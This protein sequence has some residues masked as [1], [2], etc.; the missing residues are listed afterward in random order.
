VAWEDYRGPFADIFL[1]IVSEDGEVELGSDGSPLC[2]SPGDQK[3]PSLCISTWGTPVVA[4][5]DYRTPDSKIYFLP[6]VG[7]RA[8]HQRSWPADGFQLCEVSSTQREPEVVRDMEGGGIIFWVD[9]RS[10][11]ADLYVQRVDP[12]GQLL[13]DAGGVL[14][15]GAVG[16]QVGARAAPDGGGG[17]IVVWQDSRSPENP[18]LYAQRID[19]SGSLRWDADG[20]PVCTFPGLQW[21]QVVVS[22][23]LGGALVVWEDYRGGL[24]A[25]VYGQRLNDTPG[26]PEQSVQSGD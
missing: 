14:V 6:G 18:D 8:D 11:D 4:W 7:S 2:Q 16:D 17:A 20:F 12:H 1:Q 25:D 23:G 15:C 26:M 9:Y 19:A 22:D 3:S 21:S 5:E 10:G 13:W 24:Y